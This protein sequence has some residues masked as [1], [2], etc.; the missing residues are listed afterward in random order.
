MLPPG[1]SGNVHSSVAEC[2]GNV[3]HIRSSVRIT[4]FP[5]LREG[6]EIIRVRSLLFQTCNAL[7]EEAYGELVHFY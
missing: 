3:V 7:P 1:Q 4:V 2:L 5:S 6:R